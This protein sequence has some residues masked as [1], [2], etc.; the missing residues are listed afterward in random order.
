VAKKPVVATLSNVL[1]K[2]ISNIQKRGP[3]CLRKL[4]KNVVINIRKKA[5]TAK[6]VHF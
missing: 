2:N 6:T 5:N 1:S 4:E 3:S